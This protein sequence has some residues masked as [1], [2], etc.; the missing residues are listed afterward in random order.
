MSEERKAARI[1]RNGFRVIADTLQREIEAGGIEVGSYLPTER[2]LQTSFGA[3][4]ATIR[5]ALASLVD[6]GWAKSV[7]NRGVMAARGFKPVASTKIGLID[8]GTFVQQVL[9]VKLSALLEQHGLQLVHLAGSID[10]PMEY[11]LQRA[12]DQEFAGIFV[13]PYRGFPDQET[14]QKAAKQIPIIALDH[15]LNGAETDI[16]TFDYELA[17]YQATEH[18]IKSGARRIGVTGMLDMLEITHQRFCGY[19]K[20]MFAY[21]L[22]PRSRDFLFTATS[23]QDEDDIS[24]LEMKLRSGDRPDAMLVLQDQ[25]LPKVVEA[26]LRSGI[27]VPRDIQ[28]AT[29]GDDVDITVDSVGM[30]SVAFDW[31][32]FA[33][34]SMQLLIDRLQ[35]LNRPPQV[36]FASQKLVVRGIKNSQE[37]DLTMSSDQ[38]AGYSF[39][40]PISKAQYRYSTTWRL[41]TNSPLSHSGENKP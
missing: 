34:E 13:W 11:A 3:S 21:G 40:L 35:N 14:I 39:P 38:E 19:M 27:S 6:I 20:A 10:Y 41:Q 25:Y 9:G 1:A 16:V 2:E 5:K 32:G 17:G 23:G 24:V 7:P 37:S 30:S 8:S 18:L 31:E 26:S 15:K 22:Q 33:F 36:R 4:R 12:L 29:I 28:F